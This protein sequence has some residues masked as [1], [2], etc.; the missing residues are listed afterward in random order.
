M[1]LAMT[2]IARDEADVIDAHLAFHLNAGVDVVVAVDHA[3]TDGT[4]DILAAYEREG[5]VRLLRREGEFRESQWR[6][7]MARLAAEELGADWVFASDADE[8]WWPRSSSLKDVL[9]AIPERYGIV[10]AFWRGFVPRRDD[11]S[12]F[13]ERM[14]FRLAAPAPINDPLSR[15]RPNAKVLH[16]A[17][18][19]IV[20]SRGNHAV[21]GDLVPL[22]GWYPIEVLHFP[23][24][25]QAQ[26]EQKASLYMTSEDVRFHE[27][28]R[29]A[30]EAVARGQ[31][32][33]LY[34]AT[35]L[36]DAEVERGL[37]EGSLVLDVRLRD[38]LRTLVRADSLPAAP[39]GELAF[40]LPNGSPR[41]RFPRP[42]VSDAAAYAVEAAV[43]EE[44]DLVRTQRQLDALERRISALERHPWR[45]I[46]R[47]MPGWNAR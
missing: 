34:G 12:W 27:A 45:R 3:S 1:K 19:N 10:R 2:V 11:G 38:A 17:R 29:A 18:R 35:W 37:A 22:R 30:Y 13:A 47:R 23:V 24:R 21:E 32:E 43:L 4:T 8:F 33:E 7:E 14:T 31:G 40:F 26:F 28:H 42:T 46:A 39:T 44:A 25:T 20:V 41:L 9:E 16:R 5:Y 6:T 36:D 15:W